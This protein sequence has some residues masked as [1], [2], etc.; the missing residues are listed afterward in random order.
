[1]PKK[2]ADKIK[3]PGVYVYEIPAPKVKRGGKIFRGEPDLTYYI[4]YKDGRRKVWEKVGRKSE[5]MTPQV[6]SDIRQQRTLKA[7]HGEAVETA[8]QIKQRKAEANRPLDEIA[9]AYFEQ[10][11]GSL[12]AAK[13]DRSR[14]DFHVSPILGNRP[15]SSITELDIKRIEKA[16]TGK[17]AATVWGAL[18]LVRRICNFGK[19][20]KLCQG[21]SFTIKMPRRD[22]E[23]VEFLT[24][25]QAARLLKTL[26]EWPIRG[27]DV[28]NMLRV[29]MF[30]GL[31]RGELFKL[32]WRDID[33][34]NKLV[35][36]RS[37]KGG[38]T[39]TVP[40]NPV[41][42]GILEDQAAWCA[43]IVPK[44][45]RRRRPADSPFVFPNVQGG[46]RTDSTAVDRIRTKANLPTGFRMFHGLRHHFAVTLANSGEFTLDMIGELLTHK[47]HAMTARYAAF[48]PGSLQKAGNRA[49]EL[50]TAHAGNGKAKAQEQAV[51]G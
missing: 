12:T 49:A 45:G 17:A 41:V 31:R 28:C 13:I 14:Y 39:V 47:S 42:E 34:G 30:S 18:E 40:L 37:P 44:T 27:Q 11:G 20:A 15:V 9:D 7:R 19:R 51:E 16:M 33:T 6:A 8:K 10:R 38:R 29:A 4:T 48:L 21:L 24:A 50:L 23:V 32:E 25:D 22:N 2:R 43:S 3:W 46:Q 26:D 35:R 36:L 1:M 5:G